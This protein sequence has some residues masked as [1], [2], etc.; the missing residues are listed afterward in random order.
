[1]KTLADRY[2][3][4]CDGKVVYPTAT[5][6][7]AAVARMERLEKDPF[8]AYHCQCCG[9]YHIGHRKDSNKLGD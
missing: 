5:A 9:K 7:A 4:C 3:R 8:N 2:M 1:M 6:A